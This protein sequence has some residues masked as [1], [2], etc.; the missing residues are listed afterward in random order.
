MNNV[1]D[2]PTKKHRFSTWVKDHA[3]TIVPAACVTGIVVAYVGVVVAAVKY[4]NKI[5]AENAD[6]YAK[7]AADI[8]EWSN[9]L[10]NSGKSAYQLLDG[11]FLVLANDA[12]REIVIK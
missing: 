5:A 3:D 4:D 10:I 12:T 2:L 8:T 6:A 11:R 9:E 1:T 7:Y